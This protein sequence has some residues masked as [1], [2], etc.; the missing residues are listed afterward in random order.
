[1]KYQPRQVAWNLDREG[2]WVSKLQTPKG[3]WTGANFPDPR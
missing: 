1:M 3:G 2:R